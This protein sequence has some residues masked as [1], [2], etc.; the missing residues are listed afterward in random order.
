MLEAART[1]R[2][3]TE[4]P[5]LLAVVGDQHRQFAARLE[6]LLDEVA[7]AGVVGREVID[8]ND[9][10]DPAAGEDAGAFGGLVAAELDLLAGSDFRACGH[11]SLLAR[12]R[13][14]RSVGQAEAERNPSAA[15]ARQRVPA[16]TCSEGEGCQDRGES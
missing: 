12:G 2:A 7:A 4:P 9:A 14:R 1:H 10:L 6:V 16:G 13:I 5:S 3:G 8:V 11:R 15:R